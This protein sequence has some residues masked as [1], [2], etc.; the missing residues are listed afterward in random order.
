MRVGYQIIVVDYT[1][2]ASPL[3]MSVLVANSS[4]YVDLIRLIYKDMEVIRGV[5]SFRR[6]VS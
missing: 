2:V 4:V 5:A 1:M 6:I 3:K